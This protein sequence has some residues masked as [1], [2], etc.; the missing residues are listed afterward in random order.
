MLRFP[1]SYTVYVGLVH[2]RP[3]APRELPGEDAFA[4]YVEHLIERLV[5]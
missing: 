3:E 5:Q 2:L 4:A 1:D